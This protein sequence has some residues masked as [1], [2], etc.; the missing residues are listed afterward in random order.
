M[1]LYAQ[2]KTASNRQSTWKSKQVFIVKSHWNPA[3]FMMLIACLAGRLRCGSAKPRN[4]TATLREDENERRG[5][6]KN[7]HVFVCRSPR[8]TKHQRNRKLRMMLNT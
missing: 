6:E 4:R 7:E 1:Y 8:A 2:M 5:R 3:L